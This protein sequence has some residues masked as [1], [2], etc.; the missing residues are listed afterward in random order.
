MVRRSVPPRCRSSCAASGPGGP[1]RL[2]ELLNLD[3]YGVRS[4][5][6]PP[7][8]HTDGV[9]QVLAETRTPA[10]MR[11]QRRSISLSSSHS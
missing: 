11:D 8:R 2:Y 1:R 3:V 6:S 5:P 9:M 7:S 4:R 10:F